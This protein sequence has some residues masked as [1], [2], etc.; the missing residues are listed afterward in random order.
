M[1]KITHSILHTLCSSD[2]YLR[3]LN[4]G[5]DRCSRCCVSVGGGCCKSQYSKKY[6]KNYIAMIA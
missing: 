1:Y 3:D 5:S 4:G 2:D 6:V